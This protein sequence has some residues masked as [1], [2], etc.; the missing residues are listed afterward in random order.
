MS[1]EE[2]RE[3]SEQNNL[4]AI[5]ST[6]SLES[7]SPGA[8]V[9]EG[10]LD[11]GGAGFRLLGT[12]RVETNGAL[13]C[14]DEHTL[15]SADSTDSH[16]VYVI[17]RVQPTDAC[18]PM[19]VARAVGES[20]I[21]YVGEGN[22]KRPGQ[23]FH[24]RHSANAKLGRLAYALGKKQTPE[25]LYIRVWVKG[26]V[27]KIEA[28]LEEARYLNQ[29]TLACGETPPC[30]A[31]WEGWVAPQLL[32]ALS[33]VAIASSTDPT[34]Q[35]WACT[36]YAWPRN[37]EAGPAC[38]TIDIFKGSGPGDWSHEN[39]V[40]SLAWVW[41]ASW[42]TLQGNTAHE[43]VVQPERLLLA[44]PVESSEEG[45]LLKKHHPPNMVNPLGWTSDTRVSRWTPC[46]LVE[47]MN[48]KETSKSLG[49]LLRSIQ[50]AP[51]PLAA[52]KPV[53]LHLATDTP[54]DS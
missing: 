37:T 54:E 41:P 47:A 2:P 22:A 15:G 40:C 29:I 13:E 4:Q 5:A 11:P 46:P 31:R 28:M 21:L 36:P 42:H 23:L 9:F 1:Q 20:A 48:E 33:E 51:T 43:H 26:C 6:A 45:L 38:T 16:C 17:Q 12:A 24:R 7:S 49:Q 50:K 18:A 34:A 27:E 52:L 44:V 10:D 35:W 3:R 14:L 53:F 32:K 30:N 8:E 25:A 19:P 39:W